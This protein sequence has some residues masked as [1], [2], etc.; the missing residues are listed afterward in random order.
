MKPTA[1]LINTSRGPVV[2]EAALVQA[3]AEGWIAAA[4]LDVFA[5]EPPA[6]DNSLLHM[7][8]VILTPHSASQSADGMEPRWRAS[9]DAVLALAQRRWPPSCVNR[10]VRPSQDLVANQS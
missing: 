5:Q 10:S 3:L 1:I 8:N 7:D 6:P 4:G 9:I 2:D